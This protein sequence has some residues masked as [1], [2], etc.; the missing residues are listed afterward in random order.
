MQYSTIKICH[1][2][3]W[4]TG[5]FQANKTILKCEG[6]FALLT[7]YSVNGEKRD[8]IILENLP[9]ANICEL[10]KIISVTINQ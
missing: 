5:E 4:L 3:L 7:F 10:E 9:N 8:F 2:K 1:E 6:S